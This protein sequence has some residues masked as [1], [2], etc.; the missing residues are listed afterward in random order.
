MEKVI[1]GKKKWLKNGS[2]CLTKKGLKERTNEG[3]VWAF[4]EEKVLSNL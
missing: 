3:V 2:L 1:L 4:R